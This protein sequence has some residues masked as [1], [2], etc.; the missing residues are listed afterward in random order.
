MD[1]GG[2]GAYTIIYNLQVTGS[3]GHITYTGPMKSI[4]LA[5][6]IFSIAKEMDGGGTGAHPLYKL[7]G[8][9]DI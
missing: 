6:Y 2:T 7:P 8:T 4:G 1:S 3:R 5:I 9:V